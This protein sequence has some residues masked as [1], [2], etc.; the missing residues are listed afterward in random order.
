VW[1]FLSPF[2]DDNNY[3]SDKEVSCV[4]DHRNNQKDVGNWFYNIQQHMHGR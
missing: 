2:L 4:L 3:V 1:S